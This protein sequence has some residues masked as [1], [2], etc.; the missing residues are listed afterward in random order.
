M[1]YKI[2]D[3]YIRI[4]GESIPVGTVLG[5]EDKPQSPFRTEYITNSEYEKG[6]KSFK[7]G[8]Q[9][10]G[11]LV[12]HQVAE[13]KDFVATRPVEQKWID[14]LELMGYDISKLSYDIQSQRSNFVFRFWTFGGVQEVINSTYIQ[15]RNNSK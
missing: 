8:R 15:I 9:Q 10:I 2:S 12:Y 4:N 7:Y 13:F 11:D 6:L 5:E 3:V 14:E 1:K